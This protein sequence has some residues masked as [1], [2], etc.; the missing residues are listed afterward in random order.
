MGECFLLLKENAS[1]NAS[2]S[3]LKG[4]CL[5]FYKK[6]IFNEIKNKNCDLD[7]H[8]RLRAPRYL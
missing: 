3:I 6:N 7:V 1:L 4:N 2:M 8:P 5:P